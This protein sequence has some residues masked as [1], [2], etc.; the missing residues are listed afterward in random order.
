MAIIKLGSGHKYKFTSSGSNLQF[1]EGTDNPLGLTIASG[2][3]QSHG[4]LEIISGSAIFDGP[5][6]ASNAVRFTGLGGTYPSTG[7][8]KTVYVQADGTVQLGVIGSGTVDSSSGNIFTSDGNLVSSREIGLGDSNVSFMPGA[9]NT[10]T[11]TLFIGG[12]ATYENRIGINTATPKEALEVAGTISASVDIYAGGDIFCEGIITADEFHT[13]VVSTSVQYSIGN[14]EFGDESSDHHKFTGSV[15]I[16]GNLT[17]TD[18]DSY[19]YGMVSMSTLSSSL[20]IATQGGIHGTSTLRA[21]GNVDFNGDLDVDGTTNLDVV[22][23]DGTLTVGEDDTGHNVKFYGASANAY[24]EWD[25]S[26]DGLVI[27]HSPDEVGLGV[28]TTSSAIPS[29]PQFKVGRDTNQY[30]GIKTSDR[31]AWIVHRQDEDDPDNALVQ[32]RTRFQIWDRNSSSG[33][34]RWTFES[35]DASGENV[36]SARMLI[37]SSG[38]V[39]IGTTSPTKTLDVVGD[40]SSTT[41][42]SFAYISASGDLEVKGNVSASGTISASGLHVVDRID[43]DDNP[44]VSD[45]G[46]YWSNASDTKAYVRRLATNDQI[47]IGSDNTVVFTETDGDT[48]RATFTLNTGQFDFIGS[49]SASSHISSSGTGSFTGGGIFEGNVGIGTTNPHRALVVSQSALIGGT[50]MSIANSFGESGKALFFDHRTGA[51]TVPTAKIVGWGRNSTSHLP[52]LSFEVNNTTAAG[53]SSLTQERMRILADGNV[54]IGTTAP[55]ATLEVQRAASTYAINLADT[56]TRAGLLVKNSSH[57]NFTSFTRG[58]SGLQQIQGV[59]DVGDTSY[60]LSLN[61]FGGKVSI[62]GAAATPSESLDLIGG[63]AMGETLSTRRVLYLGAETETRGPFNPIVGAIQKSGKCLFLDKEFSDGTNSVVIYNNAGAGYVSHSWQPWSQQ[64]ADDFYGFSPNG[65]SLTGSVAPNGSGNVI[66]ITYDGG[67]ATPGDGGFY[68]T[69]TGEGK[70]V[71]QVF[72]ALIPEG[73]YLNAHENSQGRD[74]DT[75]WLTNTAGTGKWEWYA[76]VNHVGSYNSNGNTFG[77]AGHVAL[78]ESDVA[79][80]WYLASCTAYDMT[81]QTEDVFRKV[82]IGTTNPQSLVTIEGSNGIVVAG[83]AE[84]T[85]KGY[86]QI[87]SNEGTATQKGGIEFKAADSGNGYG[88]R[89]SNP[90]L[91][92]GETPL[93]FQRRSNNAAW[94]DAMTILG[95]NG[96]VGIGTT[97]PG[98]KLH[99]DGIISTSNDIIIESGD[100]TLHFK[101]TDGAYQGH[102]GV[103]N[104]LMEL[105]TDQNDVDIEI[106]TNQFDNAIY[107]DDS[108]QK[109]GIGTSTPDST[110]TVQ[111]DISASGVVF[112]ARFESSGS[113]TEIQMVDDVLVTGNH[114]VTGSLSALRVTSSLDGM[115]V[116]GTLSIINKDGPTAYIK[117]KVGSFDEYHLRNDQ[118]AFQ[119]YNATD[120]RKELVADGAGGIGIG[121]ATPHANGFALQVSGAIGVLGDNEHAIGTKAARLSDVFAVQTTVGAIFETGLTTEGIG[122]LKT[123]SVVVWKNGKLIE[124]YKEDD[125]MVMGVVKQGKDEP[126]I[127]G[128]EPILVTG[129]VMEGDFLITSDVAGHA[130]AQSDE[131]LLRTGTVIAQALESAEGESNLI[132]GMIRKL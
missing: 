130:K 57:D 70:T 82:G 117:T 125:H 40:I 29:T 39:G 55:E 42:G 32:V 68:Q 81:D 53:A 86:L 123:G 45:A 19:F 62:G 7:N 114:T 90:D 119:I 14:T 46:I 64:L 31:D 85:Y 91:G 100:P 87:N 51:T 113:D 60:P 111:G 79:T 20:G 110:L 50:S 76:R 48:T 88:F 97:T 122:K 74:K 18:D 84:A 126:I 77:S 2:G 101:D 63:L 49:I 93:Y 67:E 72:Q 10:G 102:V 36:A 58:A 44:T 73:R 28:Y 127:L 9:F 121:V 17:V 69:Y 25:A 54:G 16:S 131:Y 71:V 35:A 132:K 12:N 129:D 59:N 52:Y 112:A 128:A 56:S 61:P 23:V 6:S 109:I 80:K 4:N 3:L 108:T 30:V 98:A 78:N 1:K 22:D 11:A 94:T 107:I 15:E 104:T 41:T 38:N 13:S 124:S 105:R 26:E 116:S 96:N 115:H 47:E 5:L 33:S 83:T 92:N 106:R 89:I 34:H 37:S 24:M 43:F 103:A 65:S 8:V 66:Q 120:D 75:Y 21:D 27:K 99:V 118:D 95:T